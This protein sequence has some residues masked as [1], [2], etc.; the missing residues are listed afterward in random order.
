MPTPW[1]LPA[2]RE[3]ADGHQPQADPR[4]DDA[5]I[6]LRAEQ[7]GPD[8]EVTIEEAPAHGVLRL[9]HTQG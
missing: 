3:G 4:R 1:L 2:T 5:G 6:V 7:L 8:V 9:V